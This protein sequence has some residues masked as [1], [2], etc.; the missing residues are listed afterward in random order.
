MSEKQLQG[1]KDEKLYKQHKLE[2]K[3]E[4]LEL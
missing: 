2:L 1:R 4:A 3:L